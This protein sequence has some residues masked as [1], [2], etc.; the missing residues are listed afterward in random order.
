MLKETGLWA[1]IKHTVTTCLKVAKR[2]MRNSS[3]ASLPS[4]HIQT[5]KWCHFWHLLNS[6]NNVEQ[7]L[8][9]L[10]CYMLNKHSFKNIFTFQVNLST[11]IL[12]P[13]LVLEDFHLRMPYRW[14]F[15][16]CEPNYLIFILN[17]S[18]VTHRLLGCWK[19]YI[20][21]WSEPRD[22]S[23]CFTHFGALFYSLIMVTLA[24]HV[25]HDL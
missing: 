23:S 16:R 3:L 15:Y 25:K 24:L 6:V 17:R 1:D 11:F 18:L 12:D 19:V 14:K 10:F 9:C 4:F 20:G 7:E 13:V 22:H 8:G 21:S 2:V 5:A